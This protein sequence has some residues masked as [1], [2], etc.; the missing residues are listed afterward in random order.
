[1]ADKLTRNHVLSY[2]AANGELLSLKDIQALLPQEVAERTLRRWLAE[3]VDIGRVIKQGEKRATRY[4]VVIKDKTPR[5][6]FLADKPLA[7]QQQI[8]KQLRDLWTHTSTALEGNTL[9]LGDTHFLLEQGLTVSGKPIKEHQEI[10]GHASAI[11]LLYQSIDNLVD[12]ELCFELH[13][14]IQSEI[15]E[16]TLTS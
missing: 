9:T 4:Q 11:E 3:E 14:A 12:T 13:K 2:M 8:L 10:I 16:S 15:I 6:K 7:K 5:F 1:M